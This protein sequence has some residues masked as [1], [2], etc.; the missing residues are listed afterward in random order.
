MKGRSQDTV[1]ATP[2]S[3]PEARSVLRRVAEHVRS[4]SGWQR[5]LAAFVAGS[6]SVLA[7]APIHLTPVLGVTLPVLI[8]LIDGAKG[9]RSAALTGWWFGFGYF[10]FNLFWIGEAFLVEADRF[11][12]AL[13]FAVTLLP[14]GLAF[15]FAAAT[16]AARMSWPD[17]AA[18]I[19]M[20]ALVLGSIDW[21]RGHVLTGLPWNVFGYALTYPL[22]L[23]QSASLIGVYA[24]SPIAVVVFAS[25]L[26]LLSDAARGQ[27]LATA[28]R[29]GLLTVLPMATFFA[30]GAMRLSQN[31]GARVD[32][33]RMRIVQPSV[34]QK[35]KWQ[36]L[37][38]RA[39]FEDHLNLTRDAPDGS[40]TGLAGITHVVWPEAAMP[41][42]PLEHPEALAAIGEILPPGTHLLTG[43]I[44]REARAP[45]G[46]DLPPQRQPGFNSLLVFDEEGKLAALYDKIHLVPFGEY[47]PFARWLEAVGLQ[48]L[49]RGLGAF[50]SGPTPRPLLAVPGLPPVTA[51]ICYEALFPGAIVQAEVRPGVIVNVTNDGWFG[52]TSGP[53]QHFHQARVRAVEEGVA[54][55]RVANNGIS[56][57]VGPYGDIQHRLD[58]N[59]RGAFDAALPKAVTGTL[60]ARIGDWGLFGL[61]LAAALYC[62][63]AAP[64]ERNAKPALT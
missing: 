19:V 4:L 11:A 39:I 43:A 47:L 24:M 25:P 51:L 57:V 3:A 60:Y 12:W 22:T 56:A 46:T 21:L 36:P 29:I 13:P 38:Q 52:D 28:L 62:W 17:G 26:V 63:R 27:A 41:F 59:V 37:N 7:F 8:W 42:L 53:R 14:A 23:M 54:L 33:V 18:R 5:H 6:L 31:D 61:L 55:V 2:A 30:Y 35:E 48:K 32:G 44:R 10:L 15:F 49:T 50:A 58:M 45:D 40:G 64:R 34:P 16:G 20:L 1:A 9:P